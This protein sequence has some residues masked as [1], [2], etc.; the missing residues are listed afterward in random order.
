M[1]L[2]ILFLEWGSR[3]YRCPDTAKIYDSIPV[4]DPGHY[5]VDPG[6][7]QIVQSLGES[8]RQGNEPSREDLDRVVNAIPALRSFSSTLPG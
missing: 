8:E 5:P 4:C 3:L 7:M 2:G 6:Q 1:L